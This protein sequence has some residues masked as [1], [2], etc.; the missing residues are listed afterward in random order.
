MSTI[1]I[2]LPKQIAEQIDTETKKEGFST[3]SEFL[4]ALF[5]K[6]FLK[7][8]KKELI[9]Q[10]FKPKPL[11]E[12]RRAFERTGKYNKKFIDSIIR[13]LS[14]SSAYANKTFKP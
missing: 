8:A 5:R 12:I 14:E 7:R 9:L 1:T 10:E 3:R 13:G 11:N 4:R 6:Y 2:S